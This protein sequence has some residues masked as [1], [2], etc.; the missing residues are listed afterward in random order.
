MMFPIPAY[1]EAALELA[2]HDKLDDSSFAGEIPKLNETR[3]Q[4]ACA[5]RH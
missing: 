1:I 4:T 3:A 2:S 5:G